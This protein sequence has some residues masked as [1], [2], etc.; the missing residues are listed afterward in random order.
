[1][2]AYNCNQSSSYTDTQRGPDQQRDKQTSRE[3]EEREGEGTEETGLGPGRGSR[4]KWPLIGSSRLGHASHPGRMESRRPRRR[5]A[6]HSLEQEVPLVGAASL[7]GSDSV[8]FE[9]W[10][11]CG[12]GRES[13]KV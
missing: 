10:P 3:P 5:D 13:K 2:C 7:S 11:H 6:W 12:G 9:G 1:M 4:L 8:S